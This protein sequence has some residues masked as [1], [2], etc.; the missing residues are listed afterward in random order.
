MPLETSEMDFCVEDPKSPDIR[1]GKIFDRNWELLSFL[2]PMALI[3]GLVRRHFEGRVGDAV[4]MNLSRLASRWEEI[5]NASL[6]ALEREAIQRLDSLIA[7]VE[8][9]TA[10]DG[11]EAVQIRTDLASLGKALRG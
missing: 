8:K 10:V 7:T 2:L 5:V 11:R 6:S 1:A 3:K 4:A 9:L